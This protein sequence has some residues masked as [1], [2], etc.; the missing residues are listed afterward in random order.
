MPVSSTLPNNERDNYL[1]GEE[2][3][4]NIEELAQL[5]EDGSS[6][7]NKSQWVIYEEVIVAVETKTPAVFF[8]DSP[9]ETGKTFLYK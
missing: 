3:Q 2:Q 8:V 1:I 9:G 4:Y 5:A 7:L 6:H